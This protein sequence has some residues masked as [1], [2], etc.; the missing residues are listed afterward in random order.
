MY[1]KEEIDHFVSVIQRGAAAKIADE[2]DFNPM[3]FVFG[4]GTDGSE[5]PT[6]QLYY[7][8]SEVTDYVR[9]NGVAE[10]VRTMALRGSAEAAGCIFRME[11]MVVEDDCVED[12]FAMYSPGKDSGGLE[13]AVM[14]H[15]DHLYLGHRFW[16]APVEH[17]EGRCVLGEFVEM[18]VSPNPL[19]PSFLPMELYGEPVQA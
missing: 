12:V 19:N 16:Y 7:A 11:A 6:V 15:V 18:R 14:I 9:L 4:R 1:S 8:G 2:G 17:I 5:K 13:E 3:G 10:I